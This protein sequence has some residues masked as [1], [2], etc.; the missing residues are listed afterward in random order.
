MLQHLRSFP[1]AQITSEWI[2]NIYPKNM[3][4]GK[5][6]KRAYRSVTFTFTVWL[7]QYFRL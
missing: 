5:I 1:L 7:V 4:Q 3:M 2:S 6:Q